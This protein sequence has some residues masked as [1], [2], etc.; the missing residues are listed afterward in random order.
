MALLG[1]LKELMHE[2]HLAQLWPIVS[3]QQLVAIK[4]VVLIKANINLTT[5]SLVPGGCFF[6]P[7]R[8]CLRL[9]RYSISTK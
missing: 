7:N 5:S 8:I 2:K 9:L 6:R 3:A 4:S 1:G